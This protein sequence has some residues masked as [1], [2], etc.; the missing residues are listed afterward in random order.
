MSK[1]KAL[2][3]I[4]WLVLVVAL[5]FATFGMFGGGRGHGPWPGWHDRG[6][7]SDW[8]RGYGM[9]PDDWARG[10]M[11]FGGQ[12]LPAPY[13]SQAMQFDA[14]PLSALELTPQQAQQITALRSALAE[15]QRALFEKI[16][17]QQTRLNALYLAEQ[18]DW[19]AIGDTWNAILDL[20]RQQ[21]AAWIAGEQKAQA[22]L[23]EA[24]REEWGRLKRT[25]GWAGG[26][27]P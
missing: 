9:G 20:Q 23:S 7:M 10:P 13:G 6:W 16:R 11:R 8:H 24:Q 12:G 17:E 27:A 2:G 21:I 26:N 22:L 15:Q 1:R 5:G 4:V 19:A 18:Q 14:P 3:V 25:Y